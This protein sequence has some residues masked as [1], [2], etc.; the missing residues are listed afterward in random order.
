MTNSNAILSQRLLAGSALLFAALAWPVA[1]AQHEHHHDD[2]GADVDAEAL[3]T[4]HFRASCSEA[5]AEAVDQAIAMTHHMMYVEALSRFETIV[6]AHPDCAMGHWGV[7][8]TQFQ[9]LW[10]TRPEEEALQRGWEASQRALQGT[11]S[12][13]ERALMEATAAFFRDAGDDLGYAERQER[14]ADAMRLAYEAHRDDKDIAAFHALALLAQAQGADDPHSLHDEAEAILRAV[15]A[16][17]PTHPGAI[18]YIIHGDDIDGRAERNLDIVESYA[19]IAPE[20]PHALHMPTHIYVRLGDWPAV[21]DWNRR[22]AEAAL[23]HPAGEHVSHHYP[24]AQDYI[25]YAHLQRGEDTKARDIL[26]AT[27][28]HGDMQPTPISAFHAATMPARIAVERRDW[29][30]AA[31]LQAR[32]P[33]ELPWDSPVGMWSESQSQLARGL[34]AAHDG[35][36]ERA[37]AALQRITALREQAEAEDEALMARYIRIDEH[38][39]AG[40]IAQVGDDAEAAE[41]HLRAAAEIESQVEKHPITPG[42]LMPAN[43]ALGD[44]LAAQARPREALEAYAASDTIW[45]GRYNTLLGAARAAAAA[46]DDA[47]AQRWYGRLLEI[48][49]ASQRANI[50]EAQ[51]RV[52]G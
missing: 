25:I 49:P 2:A 32:A 21:I 13:R 35:D 22:S 27:L 12:A 15:H 6:E 31:Q 1:Q 26:D 50:E 5:A 14:W 37:H 19:E 23:A 45:P 16:R 10:A 3:G 4:V 33:V 18:H 43:E 48:A 39:L 28:A 11:D 30:A 42:A 51:E 20:V 8:K 17:E 9:P 44:L 47:A 36:Q 29:E 46:D 7:A 41:T 52:A 40:W 38:I 34:G 24:H